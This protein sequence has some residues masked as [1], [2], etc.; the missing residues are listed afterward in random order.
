MDC[1]AIQGSERHV[2]TVRTTADGDRIQTTFRNQSQDDSIDIAI[3]GPDGPVNCT[4]GFSPYW[5]DAPVAG[6]YTF[7]VSLYYKSGTGTYQLGVDSWATPSS[8][9]TL[10]ED[11]FA[12]GAP[13]RNGSLP[14]GSA[15]DCYRFESARDGDELVLALDG[16]GAWFNGGIENAANERL[17]DFN[18]SRSCTI[19]GDG[20]YRFF[21]HEGYGNAVDYH[22]RITR[23]TRPVGCT[24]LQT[25][26]FG[27]LSDAQ[28]ATGDLGPNGIA[29]HTFTARA[30]THLVQMENT[31]SANWSIRGGDNAEVCSKW[32]SGLWCEL[33]ADGPY[34]LLVTNTESWNEVRYEAV[35]V[36]LNSDEGCAERVSTAW[37]RPAT[38]I[39]LNSML[40]VACLPFEAAP[41]ERVES[42][43]SL[44]YGWI[45]DRT[46]TRICDT[47]GGDS[48]DGCVLPGTGPYRLLAWY[49]AY[50]SP[51]IAVEV[52]NLSAPVG[53]PTVTPGSF[54]TAP[55][56]F[57][58]IRC[59]TLTLPAA[60]SYL[61][62]AVTEDNYVRSPRVYAPTGER[63]CTGSWCAFPAA[64][65]YTLAVDAAED[66]T[67]VLIPATTTSCVPVSDQGVA[68]GAV[69][70]SF[71]GA[72][73]IDCYQLAGPAGT[74]VTHV[75][76]GNAS[77]ASAP[78][79]T[80]YDADGTYICDGYESQTYGCR[81]DGTAP[82]RAVVSSREDYPTG[83]YRLAFQRTAG[84]T[85]CGAFPQGQASTVSVTA[86]RF[87]TCL[88]IPANGHATQEI[89]SFA[90]TA[91]AGKARVVVYRDS[92]GGVA[93][94]TGTAAYQNTTAAYASCDL[95]AGQS[96]SALIIADTEP[97]TFRLSRHDATPAGGHCT[98]VTS[99]TVGGAA[100][101][102][103]VASADE[104]RCHRITAA[105][106]RDEFMIA[107][108]SRASS[109][110]LWVT[111]PAGKRLSCSEWSPCRTTGSTGYQVF[112]SANTT[113]GPV[114]YEVDTWRTSSSA[115]LPAECPVVASSAYGF[116]PIS[117]V[118]DSARTGA[119]LQVPA[120]SRDR[121]EV[122]IE[123]TADADGRT[124]DP[125]LVNGGT[126]RSCYYGSAGRTCY[127]EAKP[128][129]T[130]VLFVL[131]AGEL[132]RHPFRA[133]A[134]CD[135]GLCGGTGF[136]AASFSPA[137]AV[138]GTRTTITVRGTALHLKDVVQ[139]TATGKP[140]ITAT[141]KAVS[142]DR[143]TL[144]A[145]AAL[146]GAAT[147]ARTVTVKPFY[148]GA[149]RVTVP[150]T[151]TVAPVPAPAA[152]RNTRAPWISGTVRV[153]SKVT[154]NA[155]SWTPAATSYTYRWMANG[156]TISGA[157][158]ATYPVGASVVG[159]KLTVAITAKRSGHP[160]GARTSAAVTI[161][162]GVAPRASK[163][164]SITGTARK[165][166]TV[167][168][169][170][171]TWSP[172]AD[173]Y[174]YQWRLNGVAIKGATRSSLKLT[175]T[176]VGKKVTV[177]VVAKRKGHTDGRATSGSVKVKK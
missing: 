6:V 113:D 151:F 57:S 67:T 106:A 123:N 109:A 167:K 61:V 134:T 129:E 127:A 15:G 93:C 68:A 147:G 8:C 105:A 19:S 50:G 110:R 125:Y 27:T 115:G 53:C 164:P 158:A 78:E 47:D 122:T 45:T 10:D 86:D 25:A 152:L 116:G 30:G 136:S 84:M 94:A 13:G 54:G 55:A 7:T 89:V 173:S 114:P 92:T 103:T 99:T 135:S 168:V 70:G 81:L 32:S 29:C 175:A 174:A 63:I 66:F 21:L 133:E 24:A 43:A 91:G 165:N 65:S 39:A 149:D 34:T 44:G 4:I 157:T 12:I 102:G 130:K 83:V 87:A 162:K 155:G 28:R 20:P 41:G 2:F 145:E 117:G 120:T 3:T 143:T 98:A 96:Y 38:R 126:I 69:A 77:G 128:G 1:P 166:R 49:T 22:L 97:S 144:T 148:S 163:A 35:A 153:G 14:V 72:G 18:Y 17:C 121:F 142:A 156:A 79:L 150:A 73:Q 139:L 100:S 59:R 36:A 40:G 104:V 60:G 33:P 48:G 58:S 177:V 140:A 108:R 62:R 137:T 169:S 74:T 82:F 112:V 85:G 75:L 118:L 26:H 23:I 131:R 80:I 46:G 71:T 5:C 146:T 88:T 42:R 141:V 107:I 124:P 132:G 90:R 16:S 161:A 56:G 119:C 64:G 31:N 9:T 111:D 138:T 11:F 154:A 172:K 170:V 76:P 95:V 52:R 101:T 160:S 51:E 171:G 176:M 159:K 37:D